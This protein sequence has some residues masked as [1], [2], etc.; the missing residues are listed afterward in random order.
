MGDIFIIEVMQVV[1]KIDAQEL[2]QPGTEVGQ[3]NI[4]T[5]LV[6]CKFGFIAATPNVLYFFRFFP[7][8]VNNKKGI[9]RCILKWRANEFKNTHITALTVHEADPKGPND[10][11]VESNLAV[12]TK[13]NQIIY[14]NLYKQI[15]F[16]DF[17]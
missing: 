14:L 7:S 9:F 10:V 3:R 13:N 4:F 6:P 11:C 8:K 17:H 12:S 1:Q 16:P 2:I 5:H 15:Y